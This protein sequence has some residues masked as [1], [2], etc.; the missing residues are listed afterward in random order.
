[1]DRWIDV[2]NQILSKYHLSEH[3]VINMSTY[4][5]RQPKNKMEVY[6][7]NWSKAK[8]YRIYKRLYVSDSV[9]IMIFFK[10]TTKTKGT[11]PKWPREIYRVI[12]KT[13]N[14]YLINENNRRK[15]YLRH[16]LREV[17]ST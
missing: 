8:N 12:S 7:N 11:D 14:E 15:V 10:K 1:M 9:R 4:Q 5:A 17:A 13:G 3:S 2:Y 16:E 6:F